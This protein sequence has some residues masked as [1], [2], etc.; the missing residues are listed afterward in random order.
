MRVPPFWTHKWWRWGDFGLTFLRPPK[1]RIFQLPQDGVVH[2]FENFS[3]RF[4]KLRTTSKSGLYIAKTLSKG[5]EL[6]SSTCGLKWT[7][8]A[9][10][11]HTGTTASPPVANRNR[12]DI[13]YNHSGNRPF[14]RAFFQYVRNFPD[15]IAGCSNSR[16]LSVISQSRCAQ[17]AITDT[18]GILHQVKLYRYRGQP[19]AEIPVK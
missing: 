16:L 6:A 15:G 17:N 10:P 4:V 18:I 2:H 19:L 8:I 14:S 7:T 9:G 1:M 5:F 12:T 3:E 13:P 11:R